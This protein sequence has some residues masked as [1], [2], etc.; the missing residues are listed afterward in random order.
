MSVSIERMANAQSSSEKRE[1]CRELPWL[2]QK[3]RKM[4]RDHF[5][6][7]NT[8]FSAA[9]NTLSAPLVYS[10]SKCSLFTTDALCVR[11]V[12]GAQSCA[13]WR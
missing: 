1:F 10:L 5:G 3:Q 13:T 6:I 12:S 8:V 9:R 7:F 11:L 2:N 4:C